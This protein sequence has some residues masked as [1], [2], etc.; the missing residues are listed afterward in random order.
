MCMLTE[1]SRPAPSRTW[2]K[3]QKGPQAH[4]AKPPG[5]AHPG[6]QLCASPSP[7]QVCSQAWVQG[8]FFE[9]DN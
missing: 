8:S 5:A 4:G 2:D 1:L 7:Q 9:A 3:L 6:L